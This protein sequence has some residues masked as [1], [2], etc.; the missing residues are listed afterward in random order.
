MIPAT[1]P[2]KK[3]SE[4]AKERGDNGDSSDEDEP[5][6]NGG[7]SVTARNT[8]KRQVQVKLE[9][10]E[11]AGRTRK[12][13]YLDNADDDFVDNNK[14][15]KRKTVDGSSQESGGSQRSL[16]NRKKDD[17]GGDDE[18]FTQTID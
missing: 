16:R 13:I 6:D 1:P 2:T 14:A 5:F 7:S 9:K 17:D 8:P 4:I 15:K 3:P 10:M 12:S 11:S 18:L